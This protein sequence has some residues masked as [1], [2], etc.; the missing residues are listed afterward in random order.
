MAI[1]ESSK[2]KKYYQDKTCVQAY[3]EER[4]SFPLGR[5]LHEKQVSVVN[6]YISFLTPRKILEL[7]CGPGRI[8][9]DISPP[10]ATKC[11]AIDASEEMLRVA[12][13]RARLLNNSRWVFFNQDI[14]SM[15]LRED[16][17]LI[18]SFRF[19]RHFRRTDRRK[20][21]KVVKK[22][23]VD[24]GLF[25]FD[26]VNKEISWPL[27]LKE[28][29]EKYPV[30]DKLYTKNEFLKEMREE[31]FCV[32]ELIPVYPYYKL[33]SRI[34]IYLGPRSGRLTYKL[35]SFI[36]NNFR[37]QNLEWIAVCQSV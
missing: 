7:A 10:E 27:R 14:F 11:I 18:F 23:L 13:E 2:I 4:F 6:R 37:A 8:T 19:I 3:L 26:V 30:Y 28:G 36:E 32:K 21:Y 1:F 15:D 24:N 33:L 29:L 34:Q 17:D 35:L 20:I 5:I 16:F 25:I 12:R 31:G 9:L 22:H